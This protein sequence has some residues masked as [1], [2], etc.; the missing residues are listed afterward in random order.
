MTDQSDVRQH[1]DD[2]VD[3][4]ESSEHSLSRHGRT[5]YSKR[6]KS[7]RREV[8]KYAYTSAK[9]L[10]L[11]INE[12]NHDAKDCPGYLILSHRWMLWITACLSSLVFTFSLAT[13]LA[14]IERSG[15]DKVVFA[16]SS[17]SVFVC[18]IVALSFFLVPMHGTLNLTETGIAIL[19]V[20]LWSCE[21]F[22]TMGVKRNLVLSS[23][24]L[25]IWSHNLFYSGWVS[26]FLV[27]YLFCDLVTIDVSSGMLPSW[28]KPN[29]IIRRTWL[30]SLCL[31]IVL[32]TVALGT[33]YQGA[34]DTTE[35]G[36]T[37]ECSTKNITIAGLAGVNGIISVS[38]FCMFHQWQA[39][40]LK[41]TEVA[42]YGV[43]LALLSL[44]FSMANAVI[45]TT[46]S[47]QEFLPMGGTSLYLCWGSFWVT[48][49][50]CFRYVDV[51]TLQAMIDEQDEPTATY[52]RSSS[53]NSILHEE[54][55]AFSLQSGRSAPAHMASAGEIVE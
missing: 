9:D 7:G 8:V 15:V 4:H 10:H 37:V 26:F 1:D 27:V 25:E 30:L 36:S 44:I 45:Y 31:S 35:G 39:N 6:S 14:P 11:P 38:S 51:F 48:L 47:R 42:R 16:F 13:S 50:L 46:K 2:G 55:G 32:V 5:I 40:N 49:Y 24:G 12:L 43:L 17:I 54:M 41:D 18:G 52:S 21:M 23:N 34:C 22:V 28:Y 53:L 19:L 3:C 33:Q 20:C 29:N